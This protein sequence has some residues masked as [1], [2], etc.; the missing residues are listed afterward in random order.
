M[1]LAHKI[2]LD[3]TVKQ[4]RYFYNAAGTARFA[5]NWALNQWN[6]QYK[7]NQKPTANKLKILWNK[8]RKSDWKVGLL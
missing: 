5:Y 1:I 6:E 4:Q 8:T 3:P 2:Q 7:L